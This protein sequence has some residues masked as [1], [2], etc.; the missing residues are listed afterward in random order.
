MYFL[1]GPKASLENVVALAHG[2]ENGAEEIEGVADLRRRYAA[3]LLQTEPGLPADVGGDFGITSFS[4]GDADLRHAFGYDPADPAWD[5]PDPTW[6]LSA[7]RTAHEAIG[8]VDLTLR[9]L[10]DSVV[11]RV[12]S[13]SSPTR[14]GSGTLYRGNGLIYV[15]PLPAWTTGDICEAYVHELTHILLTLDE[16][17]FGHYASYVEMARP[18]N[19]VPTAILERRQP[20]HLAFHS[21]VVATEVLALRDRLAESSLPSDLHKPT[22]ALISTTQR[23]VAAIR[24]LVDSHPELLLARGVELLAALERRLTELVQT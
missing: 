14:P 3:Y 10:F 20:L 2:A 4:G 16:H 7:L 15:N 1:L 13:P 12:Y 6:D 17:R 8:V 21:A 24:N 22:P 19:L 18:E 23:S 9:Q 5:G 11:L